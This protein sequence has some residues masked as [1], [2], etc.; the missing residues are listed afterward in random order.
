MEDD[1]SKILCDSYLESF[2]KIRKVLQPLT[3]TLSEMTFD[4]SALVSATGLL[5]N[6]ISE[7]WNEY[8]NIDTS[9]TMSVALKATYTSLGISDL[10]KQSINSFNQMGRLFSSENL[11]AEYKKNLQGIQNVAKSLMSVSTI[12]TSSLLRNFQE[13]MKCFTDEIMSEQINQLKKVDYDKVISETMEANGTLK[14]AVDTAYNFIRD[15][16]DT[17][18][19]G[20]LE[21]DFANEQ[22]IQEAINDQINNPIGF[23]E[24]ILNWA[25]EKRKK[26]C[27][28]V[29]IC[30]CIINIFIMPYLQNWGLTVT[31]KFVSNVKELPKKGAEVI[32]QLKENVKATIIENTNYYYK[33]IFTDE[34]GVE[35]EGYVAKRNLKIIDEPKEE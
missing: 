32:Y 9:K 1:N 12:D 5:S 7:I 24:K 31:T 16:E 29:F 30:V 33:V 28:A 18:K 26:Y 21:T 11:M 25:E 27:I 4:T 10:Y 8:E 13:S 35:R 19:N 6:K 34:N 14:A 20:D 22:E 15:K 17:S 23:Q 2:E 3:K